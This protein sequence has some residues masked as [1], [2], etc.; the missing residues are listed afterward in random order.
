MLTEEPRA[1]GG[2]CRQDNELKMD[3]DLLV[4]GPDWIDVTVEWQLPAEPSSVR[5][6]PQVPVHQ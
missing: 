6:D 1:L 4:A 3:L 2:A 5:A